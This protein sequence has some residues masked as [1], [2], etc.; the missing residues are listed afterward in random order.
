MFK[1][2]EVT[3]QLP[4]I[5]KLD[6]KAIDKKYLRVLLL[7][8]SSVT[9]VLFVGLY[10]LITKNLA[11]QIPEYTPYFYLVLIL[12]LG[13]FLFFLVLGFYKRKYAV[14]AQDI[15]YKKGVIVQSI[16]TV[17]FA[18][19]QHVELE[20]KPFSRLF[21]L[22]SIKIFTAGESGGDLKINGLPKEEAKKIKE[23]ITHFINE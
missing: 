7:N 15:S 17:P 14:R 19:I 3:S 20:E 8:F 10:F 23:F 6:F 9:I 4:D 1:N 11:T 13:I 22:A 21:K 5:S 2:I 16:T 12:I 18:R